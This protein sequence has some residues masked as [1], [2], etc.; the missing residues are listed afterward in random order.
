MSAM[1]LAEAYELFKGNLTLM[2]E[3]HEHRRIREQIEQTHHDGLA[4]GLT[5]EQIHEVVK[6]WEHHHLSLPTAVDWVAVRE[7][8][9]CRA[10]GEDWKPLHRTSRLE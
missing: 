8:L 5:E 9:A 1:T 4:M 2:L 10:R 6:A 3:P 7:S